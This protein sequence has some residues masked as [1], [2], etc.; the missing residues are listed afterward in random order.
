[1]RSG[2]QSKKLTTEQQAT[3]A[4][5]PARD[6]LTL[7]GGHGSSIGPAIMKRPISQAGR[8]ATVAGGSSKGVALPKKQLPFADSAHQQSPTVTGHTQ[9]FMLKTTNEHLAG[10]EAGGGG[11]VER[12]VSTAGAEGGS[13]PW[14]QVRSAITT[15]EKERA[16]DAFYNPGGG[17]AGGR[18]ETP[19]SQ[20]PTERP[21]TGRTQSSSSSRHRRRH[22]RDGSVTIRSR[23]GG[24]GASNTLQLP[25][26]DDIDFARAHTMAKARNHYLETVALKDEMERRHDA[27]ILERRRQ[28]EYAAHMQR[29]MRNELENERSDFLKLQAQAK[30][31][32]QQREKE[33]RMAPTTLYPSSIPH[34]RSALW[35]DQYQRDVA[36]MMKETYLQDIENKAAKKREEREKKI[37]QER[38]LL[39][40]ISEGMVLD[41]VAAQAHK[42]GMRRELMEEMKQSQLSKGRSFDTVR[43]CVD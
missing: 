8:P 28:A 17:S 16:R 26:L 20:G 39:E 43:P 42:T 31:A 6:A 1:V 4:A 12:G 5:A 33:Y 24:E 15:A 27:E 38:D 40:K 36:A 32:H 10:G 35:H 13:N 37:R 18:G 7:G 11:V 9:G 41:H 14:G 2:G 22:H 29:Q 23:G 19:L 30:H 25:E 3:A 34:G 21:E